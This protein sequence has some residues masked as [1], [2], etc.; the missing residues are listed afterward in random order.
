MTPLAI[1]LIAY[2][3]IALLAVRPLAGHFAYSFFES[4]KRLY[5]SLTA[6][7]TQPEMA[8]W[9]GAVLTGAAIA[10]VWPGAVLWL[11]AGARMPV[12]GAERHA[13]LKQKEKRIRELERQLMLDQE[14]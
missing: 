14:S 4:E 5:P 8:Q 9:L 13:K 12:V 2:G 6:G 7:R 10:L 3:V 1:G 11:L